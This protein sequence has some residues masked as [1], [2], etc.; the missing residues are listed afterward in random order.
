MSPEQQKQA[1]ASL[2]KKDKD[3]DRDRDDEKS[4]LFSR[5]VKSIKGGGSADKETGL[6]A[7][8]GAQKDGS[9]SAG[10]KQQ[11]QQP[12]DVILQTDARRSRYMTPGDR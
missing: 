11:Q 1:A 3:R 10:S 4:G 8:A 6:G 5:L 7:P 9:G 2:S 12:P